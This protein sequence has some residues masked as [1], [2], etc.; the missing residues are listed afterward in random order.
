MTSSDTPP[1][2][3]IVARAT[4]EGEGGLAVIR[5]S[6]AEAV[7]IAG[8]VFRGP[9]LR[10]RRVVY[11][12]LHA[13]VA[14]ED[15]AVKQ[16]DVIDE[17]LALH[18]P[19]PGS[20]TGEDTVEFF[21]HGGRQVAARAVR[22]CQA[23]GAAAA[24]PGEFSRRAFLNGRLT[25]DQAEAV[26]DLI[27]AG[28][29]LAARAAVAQLRGGLDAEL[30]AVEWP[31]LDLLARLE[32]SLEFSDDDLIDTDVPAAETRRVLDE[33]REGIDRLLE[34]AP[35]G[36]L[37]REGIH[38]ALVGAPNAGKSSLFNR[39]V[40]SDRALVDPDPGTTRDIVTAPVRRGGRLYVLHDT[41]GLREVDEAAR[42]EA[43]GIA[44]AR[45]AARDADLVL[46]VAEAGCAGATDGATGASCAGAS[47][48][49]ASGPPVLR[50]LAKCDLVACAGA[51]EGGAAGGA[52]AIPT[53]S[54]T[55]EGLDALWAAIE[56]QVAAWGL[57][58]AA[59]LGVVLN[60]RHRQRLLE[61]RDELAQLVA[62]LDG[63]GGAVPGAEVV[64]TLLASLLAR[65]G[66]VSG[67]V[68]TE[69]LL[70]GIFQRFCVGK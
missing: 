51:R 12:V 40:G 63:A 61:C 58:E 64:G 3:T 59:S 15:D 41:A 28:S 22:A 1:P 20:Y 7:A 35:A 19:G 68:F 18:L 42:V 33:A 43:Q 2:P 36:R 5:L 8:R 16:L 65:L 4:P 30:G 17:I 53:S 50:V 13:P 39:L 62:L 32:G 21:C 52:G 31:L 69:Q 56:E 34:L 38:I 67:R 45:A 70:D 54:L 47:A 25:L 27:T 9:P 49:G 48:P 66:E 24:P 11:G 44:R 46:A 55:G 26:A 6:G 60:E 29:E 10:A 37:L 23:A 57:D 14:S